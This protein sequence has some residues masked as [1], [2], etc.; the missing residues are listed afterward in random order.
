M[1][2]FLRLSLPVLL[3]AV[4]GCATVGM[5]RGLP[6]DAGHVVHYAASPDS[7]VAAAETAVRQQGLAVAE[8]TRPDSLTRVVIG[9]KPLGLFSNGEYVRFR[10]ARDTGARTAVWVVSKSAK[11]FD[12]GHRDRAPRLIRAMDTQLGAQ[13]LGP[14]VGLRV[15]AAPHQGGSIVGTV[16]RLTD[17]TLVLQPGAG[18]APQPL[19]F[20]DLGRLAVSR[21]TYGH[22][23]EGALL[24]ILIGGLVGTVV[25]SASGDS[26]DPFA[27]LNVLMGT[28]V[29]ATGGALVGA[30][31]GSGTRTEVWSDLPPRP[32]P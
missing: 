10:I 18:G 31:V 22:A 14:W 21:G 25:A 6:P 11:L 15:R 23:R 9:R 29:G 30:A 5:M 2:L 7:L 32:R 1:Y 20:G 16:L 28:M 19:A 17:D 8:V 13:A 27:R 4:A 24:G 12:L 3:A 26:G